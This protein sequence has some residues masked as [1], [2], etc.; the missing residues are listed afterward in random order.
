MKFRGAITKE[1]YIRLEMGLYYSKPITIIMPII[2]VGG[3]IVAMYY[4]KSVENFN[5]LFFMVIMV[6]CAYLFMV[7]GMLYSKAKQAWNSMMILH[8][9]VDYEIGP[10]GIYAEGLSYASYYTYDKFIKLEEVGKFFLF[11]SDTLNK[12]LIPKSGLSSEEVKE[13]RGIFR[14]IEV[15]KTKKF[16]K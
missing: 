16:L 12:V 1:E 11:Y 13:L 5:H 8:E 4:V 9:V 3:L 6:A 7:P 14:H 10:D 2:S 15:I